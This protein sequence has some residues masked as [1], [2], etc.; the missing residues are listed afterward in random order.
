MDLASATLGEIVLFGAMLLAAGGIAGLLAGMFGVGG[1]AVIVPVLYEVFG[2]V[3]FDESVRMH[4]AVGTSLAII[5][6]TS[7]RSF[8]AHRR[9]DVVD[10]DLLRSWVVA[11]PLGAVLASAVAAFVDGTVLIVVFI[12]LAILFALRFL[13]FRSARPIAADIPRQ[14]VRGVLGMLIGFFSTLMGIGGGTFNNTFMT[15]FGR[16]MIQAVATSSGVG[17]LVSFPALLGFIAAGWGNPDLPPASLGYVSLISVAVLVPATFL[18]APFGVRI[19]HAIDRRYL[20][21]GFGVFLL[22]VAVRF[23][24]SLAG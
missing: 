18:A 21:I 13:F 5:V 22:A 7:I 20:E 24:F 19:A 9:R 12:V 15:M 1:G 2:A 16:P 4:M 3:G 6:P 17:V 14:P 23:A 10:M 11:V 8:L